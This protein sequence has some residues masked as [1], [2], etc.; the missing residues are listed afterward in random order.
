MNSK[1]FSQRHIQKGFTLIE[2]MVVVLIIGLLAATASAAFQSY[3]RRSKT[4]EA[5]LGLS[6]M[7][8]G[9]TIYYANNTTFVSAGPTPATP[10]SEKVRV[11]FKADDPRWELIDFSFADP[12]RFSFQAQVMTPPGMRAVGDDSEPPPPDPGAESVE[13]MAFGDLNGDGMLS[14][15]SRNI[16]VGESGVP[17]VSGLFIFDELE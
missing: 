7:A 1:F 4:P 3:I 15:F 16:V 5:V 6:R 13:C 12:I 10:S 11:D 2:I 9:Q 14:V 17:A 8:N